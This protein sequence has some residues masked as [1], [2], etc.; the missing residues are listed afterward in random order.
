SSFRVSRFDTSAGMALRTGS[1]LMSFYKNDLT[2]IMMSLD[3][4]NNLATFLGDVSAPNITAITNKLTNVTSDATSVT[5]AGKINI[6]HAADETVLNINEASTVNAGI[7]L[8]AGYN[9]EN[10]AIRSVQYRNISTGTSAE[11]RFLCWVFSGNL[12]SKK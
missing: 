8:F 4:T 1:T 12:L 5:F 11:I 2:T 7:S 10:N 3:A 6:N 9:C